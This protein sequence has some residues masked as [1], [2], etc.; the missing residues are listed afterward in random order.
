MHPEAGSYPTAMPWR[1]R[2]SGNLIASLHW[3]DAERARGLVPAEL[4]VVEFVP[5]K[6]LGGLFLADYGPGSDLRYKELIVGAA[7]VWHRR[8]LVLWV[9]DLY[10]DTAASVTGGRALL[11]A[12]KQ[13]ASFVF[14]E[15]EAR[16]DDQ[17]GPIC[18]V[19]YRPRVWLWRQ[20]V[21]LAAMHKDVRD[22]AGGTVAL[23]GEEMRGQWGVAK[24][25]VDI[26]PE[27]P[28]QA[29]A[30]SNPILGFCGR[31][32]ELLLGGAP[33]LPLQSLQVSSSSVSEQFN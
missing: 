2:S 25:E 18:R 11:G 20:R 4:S 7:T 6:T 22:A 26:L 27:S 28:L 10:V 12:P 33:F 30:L 24:V 19:Q 16:V 14:A 9:S 8:R 13:L 3:V 32:V 15:G 31:N 21:R 5:G 17:A 23:H 29:L 1:L